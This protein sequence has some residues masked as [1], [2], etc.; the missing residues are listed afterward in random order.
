MKNKNINF[1]N[2]TKQQNKKKE[3]IEWLIK[4]IINIYAL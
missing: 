4:I 1:I 2:K 3:E